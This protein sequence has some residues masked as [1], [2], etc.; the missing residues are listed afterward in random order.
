MNAMT[1]VFFQREVQRRTRYHLAGGAGLGVLV[2][3]VAVGLLHEQIAPFA[4][5]AGGTG[6]PLSAPS[7][8]HPLGTDILGRDLWSETIHGL[9][10]TLS[11]ATAAFAFGLI[12]G[13]M[14]GHLAVSLLGVFGHALR[15]VVNVAASIPAV[16]LAILLVGL[17]GSE[18]FV[19]AA[20]LALAPAAFVQSFDG[21]QAHRVADYVE[22]ARASG[23]TNTALLR[24][25]LTHWFRASL[26]RD[27]ANLFSTALILVSTVSFFGFGAL[28]PARDLGLVIASA[29]GSLPEAWWAVAGPAAFL[30][31][32]I[33]VARAAGGL[34]KGDRA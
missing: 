34:G 21:A 2:V 19:L 30:I 7:A 4:V 20:G 10:V 29:S 22:Y 3:L 15:V 31:V 32:L 26:I 6:A 11:T 13:A 23:V 28:P 5:G 1:E 33:M 9:R 12:A 24:R 25:D 27:A 14:A 16:L 8:L 18:Q 17:L